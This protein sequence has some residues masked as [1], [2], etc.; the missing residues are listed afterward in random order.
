MSDGLLNKQ[1]ALGF[2][3]EA[4]IRWQQYAITQLGYTINF[5]FTVT[6]ALLG[7]ATKEV[8]EQR[9]HMS[10]EWWPVFLFKLA[11]PPLA[12]S[13]VVALLANV[14]RS[15]DFR[16]TRRAALSRL[17]RPDDHQMFEER[18]ERF[19]KATWWLF[20]VQIGLF[21]VGIV[22]LAASVYL[23]LVPLV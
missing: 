9:Q 17:E 8:I 5:I 14:A 1:E 6:A 13:T 15:L 18:A 11:F 23:G 22:L 7:L 20:A 4:Y 3:R 10:H 19:G 2:E 12:V 16:Y 21:G